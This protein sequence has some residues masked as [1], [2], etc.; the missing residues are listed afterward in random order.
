M[1]NG[2]P[3]HV[4]VKHFITKC[5]FYP[6]VC[7]HMLCASI[8][9][10][11]KFGGTVRDGTR[12]FMHDSGKPTQAS[13]DD[14]KLTAT[15]TQK[16][17]WQVVSS[18]YGFRWRVPTIWS[19]KATQYRCPTTGTTTCTR[20]FYT[21]S[22]WYSAQNVGHTPVEWFRQECRN[23]RAAERSHLI[24]RNHTQA[25]FNTEKPYSRNQ[26]QAW[27]YWISFQKL[28]STGVNYNSVARIKEFFSAFV[29]GLYTKTCKPTLNGISVIATAASC[30]RSSAGVALGS[31]VS[32]T[33]AHPIPSFRCVN[34]KYLLG[35]W[36]ENER[37]AHRLPDVHYFAFMNLIHEVPQPE[38][39]SKPRKIDWI[40]FPLSAATNNLSLL[41]R[42]QIIIQRHIQATKMFEQ[43]NV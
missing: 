38:T 11:K 37:I 29:L 10:K 28:S 7:W 32:R 23:D 27:W 33:I 39:L 20:S 30:P 2:A 4:G 19:P 42:D 14:P 35:T 25:S 40:K 18:L 26:L 41:W 1:A 15:K 36:F 13:V 12:L 43:A 9:H 5:A 24:Q 17:Q 16:W 31:W 21:R 22:Y 3:P 6:W 34:K 8:A